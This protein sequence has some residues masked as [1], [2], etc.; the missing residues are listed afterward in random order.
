MTGGAIPASSACFHLAAHTH[1]LSPAF[2]PGKP[3]SGAGFVRSFPHAAVK[4]RNS[5]VTCV[6]IV[7]E[8]MS[9]LSVSQQPFR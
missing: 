4:P 1:H 7:W 2:N 5:S 8:P 3:S 6:Q 9:S